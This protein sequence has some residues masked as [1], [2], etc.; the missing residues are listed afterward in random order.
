MTRPLLP[1]EIAPASAAIGETWN[2]FEETLTRFLL[3]VGTQC[4][5]RLQSAMAE[6]VRIRDAFARG[7]VHRTPLMCRFIGCIHFSGD[8]DSRLA[9]ER[10]VHPGKGLKSFTT[11]TCRVVFLVFWGTVLV[12]LAQK[13][14]KYQRYC[15]PVYF[16]KIQIAHGF[17]GTGI[18]GIWYWYLDWY[19]NTHCNTT[20]INTS[21]IAVC[22]EIPLIPPPGICG[23]FPPPGKW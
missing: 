4:R 3:E 13:Y 5:S 7:A 15:L 11:P 20:G 22:I 19:F 16:A 1:T 18:G 2:P 21:G 9:H 12:F 23:I 6:T 8:E 14:H 17:P 10:A